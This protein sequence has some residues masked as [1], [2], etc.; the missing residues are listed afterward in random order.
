MIKSSSKAQS[1]RKLHAELIGLVRQFV[2]ARDGRKC[3][4]CGGTNVLQLAH[5]IPISR[6]KRIQYEP[7]NAMCLCRADHLFWWHK[8]P[9]EAVEWFE[10]KYPGRYD[11]LQIAARCAPKVDLKL[12]LTVWRAE[13]K[14]W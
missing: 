9:H 6:G 11:R 7:D 1:R 3:A 8:S 10:T 5:V 12:L 2:F 13:A 4:K 14:K